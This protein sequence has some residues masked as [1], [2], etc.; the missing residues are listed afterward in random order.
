MNKR[1]FYLI[2]AKMW[3]RIIFNTKVGLHKKLRITKKIILNKI[4]N[5]KNPIKNK[6]KILFNNILKIIGKNYLFTLKNMKKKIII[7]ISMKKTL[8]KV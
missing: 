8:L 3:T 5:I 6:I 4:N 2:K 7:N 1:S